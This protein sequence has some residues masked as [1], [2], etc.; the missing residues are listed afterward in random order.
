MIEIKQSKHSGIWFK[1][2]WYELFIFIFFMGMVWAF[3]LEAL[4]E[5]FNFGSKNEIMMAL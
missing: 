5:V 4:I 3:G 2:E 1:K